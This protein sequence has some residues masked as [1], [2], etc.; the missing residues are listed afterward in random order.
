MALEEAGELQEAARVFE[1]AGEHAQAALLRLEHART[2]RDPLERLDVLREGCAR[3]PGTT[4]E[5]RLLHLALAEALLDEAD[6]VQS[7][8]A[9]RRA[10]ELEAAAAL[11]EADEGGRAGELYESLRLLNKAAAA[12]ERAGEIGKLELVLEVLDR[13]DELAR[14]R[15]DL[16]EEIDRAIAQGQRR[17]ALSQLQEHVHGGSRARETKA[18]QRAEAPLGAARPRAPA[19]ALVSRLQLLESKLLTRDRIDLDWGSGRVTRIR[20][21]E[22]FTLGRAPDS[23]LPLSGASLSRRHVELRLAAIDGLPQLCAVD[24]GSKVGSFWNGEALAPGEPM[25]LRDPGELACGMTAPVPVHP[26]RDRGGATVGG[27][28]QSPASTAWLLFVPSGGPLWLSPEIHVPARVFPDRGFVVL[29]LAARVQAR[30][31]DEPLPAGANIELMLGDRL[32]LV[33]AP[34]TLEVLG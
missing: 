14:Q 22:R 19:V 2:L 30:L 27:L 13:H 5:G 31:H 3:N 25:P 1:Y 7:S 8:G 11:E 21:G 29:D 24:L 23:D 33:A 34:L 10:L 28:L 12:Y 15:R 18:L 6:A 20:M 9:Q 17:Y 16:I 26:V 4:P 32:S